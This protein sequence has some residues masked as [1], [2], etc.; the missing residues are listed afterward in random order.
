MA[1]ESYVQLAADGSGKQ[2]DTVLVTN[3]ATGAVQ[4]RQAVVLADSEFAANTAEVGPEGD[5]L[6]RSYT[7]EDLLLQVLIELRVMNT[8]L[9]ATLNSRDDLDDLRKFEGAVT[10][11]L[12]Q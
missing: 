5:A 1:S 9:Q 4:H 2:I 12:S 8:I 10:Q 6:V 11:Q 7:M 3:P